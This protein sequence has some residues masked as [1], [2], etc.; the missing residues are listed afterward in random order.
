MRGE[1]GVS[2][3]SEIEE[4]VDAIDTIAYQ[5][6]LERFLRDFDQVDGAVLATGDGLLIASAAGSDSI[7]PDAIAAMSA[8]MLALADTLVGQAGRAYADNL[9]SEAESS[10]L[11]ILHA[12]ELILT[13]VGRPN[14]NV[15]MILTAARRT[16]NAIGVRAK[17]DEG[18]EG[19]VKGH[20]I[21]KDP[22]ALLQRVKQELQEMRRA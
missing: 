2:E 18:L 10:T 16:A 6:S 20:E 22:E 21:L 15:G 4:S 11:V 13:V 1:V 7:E 17:E 3:M 8:S 14:V 12:G 9:I 19:F 5:A